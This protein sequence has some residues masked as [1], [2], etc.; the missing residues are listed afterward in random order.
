MIGHLQDGTYR[1][2]RR[3]DATFGS[4]AAAMVLSRACLPLVRAQQQLLLPSIVI[5]INDNDSDAVFTYNNASSSGATSALLFHKLISSSSSSSS[6]HVKNNTKEDNDSVQVSDVSLNAAG[7]VVVR[8]LRRLVTPGV[9][10]ND[11]AMN[12]LMAMFVRATSTGSDPFDAFSTF[13]VKKLMQSDFN[14]AQLRVSYKSLRG[15][16]FEQLLQQEQQQQQQQ[17]QQSEDNEVKELQKRMCVCLISQ[18]IIDDDNNNSHS[19]AFGYCT[20]VITRHRFGNE[21]DF[22][23]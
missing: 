18:R 6:L 14:A 23:Y 20:L 8:D 16:T 5:D 17:Q 13:L 4:S 12:V 2:L 15:R 3:I 10:L 11:E 19:M 7:V 9:W 1:M 22:T 21:S